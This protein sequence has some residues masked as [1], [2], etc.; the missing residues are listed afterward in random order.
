MPLNADQLE[1]N[2]VNR[3]RTAYRLLAH[4]IDGRRVLEEMDD[5]GPYGGDYDTAIVFAEHT[6]RIVMEAYEKGPT[7]V[8]ALL[9]A[10][11]DLLIETTDPA[12]LR[13]MVERC[14]V[15]AFTDGDDLEAAIRGGGR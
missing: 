3:Y 5:D 1:E 11:V 10:L 4:T 7:G 13:A 15:R 8:E 2:N 12:T 6:A 9:D 14:R